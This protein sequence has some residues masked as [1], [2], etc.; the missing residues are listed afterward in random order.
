M[1]LT[2]PALLS[3]I[4]S[5]AFISEFVLGGF[6][7]LAILSSTQYGIATGIWTSTKLL[8]RIHLL[9]VAVQINNYLVALTDSKDS[10]TAEWRVLL[11]ATM[12]YKAAGCTFLITLVYELYS[13]GWRLS[14]MKRTPAVVNAIFAANSAFVTMLF[15]LG[16]L[17]REE[18]M[19]VKALPGTV[20]RE[21]PRLVYRYIS[22]GGKISEMPF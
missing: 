22:E 7:L 20:V 1:A 3:D 8:L 9:L 21:V 2:V 4:I 13:A 17:G 15:T 12:A 10:S 11:A 6:L 18:W 14:R 5:T 16:G 19:Y